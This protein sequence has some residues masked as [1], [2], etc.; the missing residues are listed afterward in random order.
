MADVVQQRGDANQHAFVA[1][2]RRVVLVLLEQRQRSAG[3]VI[4]P[5]RVLEARVCGAGID[6]KGEA[7]LANVSEPLERR[8]VDQLEA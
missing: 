8:R 4:G 2:D 7:E 6:E 5:E 1:A 3:E